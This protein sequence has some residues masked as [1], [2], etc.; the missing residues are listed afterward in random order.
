MLA[1]IGNPRSNRG[2]NLDCNKN[3]EINLCETKDFAI[4]VDCVEI[5][6]EEELDSG[7]NDQDEKRN[8][9]EHVP[10]C[11]HVEWVSSM[12]GNWGEYLQDKSMCENHIHQVL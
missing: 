9:T 8:D 1:Q 5:R 10:I 7:D 12:R 3:G 11:Y 4:R 2:R 6:C